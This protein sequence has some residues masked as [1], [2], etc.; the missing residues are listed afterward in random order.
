MGHLPALEPAAMS[1]PGASPALVALAAAGVV[2]V[3]VLEGRLPGP[4]LR[5][6]ARAVVRAAILLAVAAALADPRV[7]REAS[8]PA[9]L[10]LVVDEG[11]AAAAGPDARAALERDAAAAARSA[12]G[13]RTVRVASGRPARLAA[14]ISSARLSIASD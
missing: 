5:R 3:V 13:A 8:L 10:V 4:P 2:L 11:A 14:A 1:F 9:R 6:A 7:E 12:G